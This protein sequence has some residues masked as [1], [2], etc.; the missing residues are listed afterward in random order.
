MPPPP[1]PPH[2]PEPPWPL[3]QF[4]L[5]VENLAHPGAK[6]FFDH[7]RADEALRYAV[8]I[9]CTWLYTPD[10]VPTKC[11]A[12]PIHQTRGLR[13]ASVCRHHSDAPR[14]RPLPYDASLRRGGPPPPVC[15]TSRSCSAPWMASHTRSVRRRT[16][17]FIFPSVIFTTPSHA[18]GTRYSACLSM[19]WSTAFN[20]TATGRLPVASSKA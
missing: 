1:L 7:I 16:R 15:S 2:D 5:R 20:T 8:V 18:R 17:K 12:C 9:V 6:L 11:V 10:S 13:S 4:T 14:S 3:P 19:K